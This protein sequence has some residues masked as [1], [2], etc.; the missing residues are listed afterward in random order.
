MTDDYELIPPRRPKGMLYPLGW[1]RLPKGSNPKRRILTEG[2]LNTRMPRT[3]TIGMNQHYIE[4][5]MENPRTP[6]ENK[7]TAFQYV[8]DHPDKFMALCDQTESP[9]INEWARKKNGSAVF[10]WLQTFRDRY[11]WYR[12]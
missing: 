6:I 4:R 8:M 2:F 3:N 12:P 11:G 9:D 10:G 5:I 7:R 1:V